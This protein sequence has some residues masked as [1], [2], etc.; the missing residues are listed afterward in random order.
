MF[1]FF[2]ILLN[3][4]ICFAYFFCSR[5]LFV[6]HYILKFTQKVIYI[7][8]I[9]F[10]YKV[11]I[12]FIII[13]KVLLLFLLFFF[14]RLDFSFHWWNLW[15]RLIIENGVIHE[16]VHLIIKSFR[17]LLFLWILRLIRIFYLSVLSFL[18]TL[19]ASI[20]IF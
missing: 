19:N 4:F 9:I 10:F 14:G 16:I 18:F 7:D 17:F 8:I 2:Y 5:W 3:F 13:C 1:Y 15:M 6:L 20:L 12:F 11:L